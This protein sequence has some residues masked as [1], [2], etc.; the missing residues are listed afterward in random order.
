MDDVV[1]PASRVVVTGGWRHSAEVM[2]AKAARF[3]NLEV[4]AVEEAGALGAAT[5]AARACG[6]LGAGDHLGRP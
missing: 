2:R 6:A 5:L 3:T 4:S 1:G